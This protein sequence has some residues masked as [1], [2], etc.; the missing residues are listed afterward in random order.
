MPDDDLALMI[1]P[2]FLGLI[3]MLFG[4]GDPTAPPGPPQGEVRMMIVQQ[5]MILCVPVRPHPAF[6]LQ[7]EEEKGP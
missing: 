7:W 1:F 6:N 4:A 3:A 2:G 5:Q